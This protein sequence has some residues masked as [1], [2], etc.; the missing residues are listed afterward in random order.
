MAAVAEGRALTANPR[1]Q[2][3]AKRRPTIAVTGPDRRGWLLWALNNLAV[4]RAGGRALAAT[5]RRPPDLRRI[6]GL[7]VV[8]GADV[9]P[10]LYGQ[11]NVAARRVDPPRDRMELDLLRWAV[12]NRRPVLG[13]CR[14]AQLLNVALGG[15][16]HQEASEVYP[17]F[18]PTA[19]LVSQLTLRRPVRVV[20]DGWV[21]RALGGEGPHPVNSLHHQAIA[22]VAAALEVTAVDE[23]GMAQAVELRDRS[24]FTVGVQWHPELMQNSRAQRGLFVALVRAAQ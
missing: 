17:G 5:P 6:D 19:G 4:R 9:D 2:Q 12:A 21:R 22:E 23:F 13:I 11:R 10:A 14:G 1:K 16:L 24:C 3:M 20:R 15:T 8:G 7:V 18:R